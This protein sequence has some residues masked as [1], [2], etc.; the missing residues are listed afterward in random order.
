[1]DH[2]LPKCMRYSKLV[3]AVGPGFGDIG[4]DKAGLSNI[5]K[6]PITDAAVELLLINP[7]T[8]AIKIFYHRLN[9]LFV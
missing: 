4:D 2:L 6:N 7:L 5:F 9:D 3:V 8:A 1:M